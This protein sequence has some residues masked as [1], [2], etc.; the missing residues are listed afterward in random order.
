MRHV[1]RDGSMRPYERLRG[2]KAVEQRSRR[3]H[4][5]PLCRDC[6]DKG[7]IVAASVPDH[8]IPLARG[9]TDVDS[10]VRCLCEDCHRKRTAEQF[11]YSKKYYGSK[12]SRPDADGWPREG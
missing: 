8:I 3:L 1:V 9:G 6:K 10:N 5:E 11:N 2:R 12:Y 4:A 7:M